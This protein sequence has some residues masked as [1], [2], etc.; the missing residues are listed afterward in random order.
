MVLDRRQ[1]GRPRGIARFFARDPADYYYYDKPVA[2]LS[3]A[4]SF[5]ATDGFLSA[6]ADLPQVSIVGEPSGGGSGATRQ[7]QLPRTE[8]VVALS[9]M[10]SFRATG[11]TFDG[12]GIAVDVEAK[13][14]LQDFLSDQDS[15][16]QRAVEVIRNRQN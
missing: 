12:N 14:T 6:F 4:G 11:K 8:I 16:L 10:A 3:S 5:S 9:S 15:V 7:F 1:S 13:P 2:V